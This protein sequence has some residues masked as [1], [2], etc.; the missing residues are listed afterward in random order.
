MIYYD[1]FTN[2]YVKEKIEFAPPERYIEITCSPNDA[3]KETWFVGNDKFL[4]ISYSKQD[5]KKAMVH[6]IRLSLAEE[7]NCILQYIVRW[8]VPEEDYKKIQSYG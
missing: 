6:K 5:I 3:Y 7:N 8:E 4:D 2:E 1:A